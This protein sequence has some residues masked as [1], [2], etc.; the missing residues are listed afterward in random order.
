M[1]NTNEISLVANQCIEEIDLC[2]NKKIHWQLTDNNDDNA[3]N[4]NLFE[5][6]LK[7]KR[8]LLF[9]LIKKLEK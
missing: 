4:P 2:I 1:Y 5:L 8:K 9:T 7:I 3:N 6:E